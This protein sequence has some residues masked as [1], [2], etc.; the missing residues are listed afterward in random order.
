LFSRTKPN[1]FAETACP[2]KGGGTINPKIIKMPNAKKAVALS[3]LLYADLTK[4]YFLF[5]EC[6]L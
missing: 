3:H 2:A 4:H 1:K 6:V 5:L